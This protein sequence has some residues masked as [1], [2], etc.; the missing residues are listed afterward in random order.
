MIICVI[1]CMTTGRPGDPGLSREEV[2][3]YRN[4]LYARSLALLEA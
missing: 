1:I 3:A 2:E 4:E